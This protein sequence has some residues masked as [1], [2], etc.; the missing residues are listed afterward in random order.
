MP[1]ASAT[2]TSPRDRG[3]PVWCLRLFVFRSM[4]VDYTVG[5]RVDLWKQ[6]RLFSI[7]VFAI[8]YLSTV[9]VAPVTSTVRGVHLRLS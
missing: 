9:I 3:R 5:S 1:L 2:Q 8:S 6:S 4:Y 7:K